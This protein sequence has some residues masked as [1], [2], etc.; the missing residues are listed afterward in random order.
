MLNRIF[1]SISLLFLLSC[2]ASAQS[3]DYK[4]LNVA[5][6]MTE[7]QERK[8]IQLL[9]V[10]TAQE[11]DQGIIPGADKIDFYSETFKKELSELDKDTPL[12]IYCRSGGRSAKASAI[13]HELGFKEVYNLLGGYTAYTNFK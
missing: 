1:L 7:I 9:D 6:F 5:D 10:R 11:T 8:Y 13:A 12:Y 2:G 4:N 3:Q